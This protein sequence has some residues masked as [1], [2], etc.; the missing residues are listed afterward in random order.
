M[1]VRCAIAVAVVSLSLAAVAA[2]PEGEIS[3]EAARALA[4][5]VGRAEP[6]VLARIA[7]ALPGEEIVL[8]A[9]RGARVE[10][11][12][13]VSAAG[14]AEPGREL[15]PFLAALAGARQRPVASR[16]AGALLTALERMEAR[17]EP[18]PEVA[19]GQFAQVA[20]QCLALARDGRLA[21][22]VR[23]VAL[24][25]AGRVSRLALAP[26][27]PP[28]ELFEDPEAIIRGGAMSMLD[29]P[30]GQRELALVA[31][32]A[33]G[34]PDPVL[35]GQAAAFLCEN[36]LAHRVTEPSPDLARMMRDV[37]DD[38][39]M[40][41]EGLAPLLGCLVRFPPIVRAGLVERV[42]SRQDPGLK[43]LWQALAEGGSRE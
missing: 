3:G 16:A 17:R 23:L 22:D 24:D 7:A 13:A 9:Y 21:P 15:L 20:G 34:D 18:D 19:P 25:A 38:Q 8:A 4:R 28:E 10:R 1:P 37:V 36:A 2:I 14:H 5:A 27:A 40:P 39:G 41:P 12:V 35:R 31:K 32:L 26:M 29:V 33:A 42:M 11:L 43:D 6:A 30:L